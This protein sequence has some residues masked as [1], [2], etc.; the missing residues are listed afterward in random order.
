MMLCFLRPV[1]KG[2]NDWLVWNYRRNRGP[3][4]TFHS[5]VCNLSKRVSRFSCDEAECVGVVRR[6]ASDG[7][8]KPLR[9]GRLNQ[10][11]CLLLF[12]SE[13]HGGNITLMVSEVGLFLL[14]AKLFLR[15][16]C[17]LDLIIAYQIQIMSAIDPS[18]YLEPPQR[19]CALR[20]RTDKQITLSRKAFNK[21]KKPIPPLHFVMGG[22]IFLSIHTQK[23]GF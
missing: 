2:V 1:E 18:I 12:E 17:Q 7:G 19:C 15:P 4:P 14:T 8:E 21:R 20:P 23:E 10:F 9:K 16:Q 22:F 3:L 5:N 6:F 11:S 13:S